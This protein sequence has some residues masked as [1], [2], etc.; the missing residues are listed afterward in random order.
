MFNPTNKR[1]EKILT[2]A[3]LLEFFIYGSLSIF[4]YISLLDKIPGVILNRPAL[5]GENS[6]DIPM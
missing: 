3:V 2:R 4:A 5:G 6:A 1:M